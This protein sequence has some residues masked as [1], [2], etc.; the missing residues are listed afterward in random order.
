MGAPSGLAPIAFS[1]RAR[2]ARVAS[3]SFY[4]DLSLLEDYW[5]QRKYHHTLS[6]PLMYALDEALS[7]VEEEGLEARYARH[8]RHHEALAAGLEAI[9]LSLLPPQGERLWTLNT[10]R[11]PDGVDEAA[12]RQQL[13]RDFNMEIGAGLGPLAGKIW[14]VGIMGAGSTLTNVLLFLTALER[15]LGQAGYRK[16]GPGGAAAAAEA[17]IA[18]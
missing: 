13:L 14:R 6:A 4:L 10:V 15:V 1:S 5:L 9:G 18:R 2:G 16:A 7:A 3:R 11:V 17:A 8:Q 12:V